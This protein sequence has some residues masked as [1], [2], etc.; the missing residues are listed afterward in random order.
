MSLTYEEWC[1]KIKP[2]IEQPGDPATV[3]SVLTEAREAYRDLY[4][5]KIS[6]DEEARKLAEENTRLMETNRELFLR[7]GQ[8]MTTPPER[9]KTETTAETIRVSDLFKEE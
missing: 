5:D 9:D 2:A 7:I 4:S 6:A 3:V 1:E 8:S